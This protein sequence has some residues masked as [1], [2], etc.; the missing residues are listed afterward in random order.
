MVKRKTGCGCFILFI[1]IIIGLV[2]Y[3][4]LRE[5]P[6]VDLVDKVKDNV[7]EFTQQ[8]ENK[9]IKVIPVTTEEDFL[10]GS[11]NFFGIVEEYF[12]P[13]VKVETKIL[14]LEEVIKRNKIDAYEIGL[15][16]F[17]KHAFEKFEIDNNDFA[18]IL[19]IVSFV[20][21]IEYPEDT[22]AFSLSQMVINSRINNV[23][24]ILLAS[25]LCQSI[26]LAVIPIVDSNNNYYLA[27]TFRDDE[28]LD[29]LQ[30]RC[31]FE[32]EGR[33]FYLFDLSLRNPIGSPGKEPGEYFR[34]VGDKRQGNPISIYPHKSN[35]PKFPKNIEDKVINVSGFFGDSEYQLSFY[36]KKNLK[37]YISNLPLSLPLLFAYAT[38]E[39]SETGVISDI[40]AYI[41]QLNSEVEKVNFLLSL[42]QNSDLTNYYKT[43]IRPATVTL[44]ERKSD[45]DT[46]S[47]IL[48][49]LLFNCGIK[50]I[51]VLEAP[52]HAC[53]AVA[54]QE[55]ETVV[56]GG[57]YINHKNKKY[58]ILDAAI[59]N[60]EWGTSIGEE[61]WKPLLDLSKFIY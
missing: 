13:V 1:I 24:R 11:I 44:F 18:K 53:L 4:Y 61:K 57:C 48:A 21:S 28:R 30:T 27:T 43:D 8:R 25:S 55:N 7:K 56:P 31:R 49:G 40:E 20:N 14:T 47:I 38:Q 26:D 5:H 36:L 2:G 16:K 6:L 22:V 50:R 3:F 52:E 42:V 59:L 29:P 12:F 60:G 45:C 41:S 54:P 58:Y 34:F 46:R 9:K 37:D 39:M 19:F 17:L 33:K 35:L 32:S 10:S 23:S 51:L 15:L